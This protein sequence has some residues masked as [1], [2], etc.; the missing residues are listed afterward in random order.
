[1]RIFKL[2]KIFIITLWAVFSTIL[3]IGCIDDDLQEEQG[4]YSP[5]DETGYYLSFKINLES[6]TRGG[7]SFE[8]YEDYID[9]SK[10][11][12]LFF[13]ATDK[14]SDPSNENLIREFTNNE[15]NF[16]P[17]A[18][19]EGGSLKNWYIQIPVPTESFADSLRNSNF[20]V[21]V[22]ANWPGS[23]PHFEHGDN[24]NQL[25]HLSSSDTYEG[26]NKDTYSFLFATDKNY[27]GTLGMSSS[28][29]EDGQNKLDGANQTIR[30]DWDPSL[31]KNPTLE[32]YKAGKPYQYRTYSDLWFL[33]NFGGDNTS[34]DNYI[35]YPSHASEW[36][37]RN[38]SKLRQ[39]IT[40]NLKDADLESLK[41]QTTGNN[42]NYLTYNKIAGGRAIK[43]Q[44][45]NTSEYYYGTMI[46]KATGTGSGGRIQDTDAGVFS[47]IAKATG[48]LYITASNAGNNSGISGKAKLKVQIGS[49]TSNSTLEFES[50]PETKEM[51]ISITGDEER[52][53]IFNGSDNST[54][55]PNKA[56]IYQIEYVQDHYL[57]DTDRIGRVPDG[58]SQVIPMYGIQKFE[59]LTDWKKGTVYDLSNFNKLGITK[60]NSEISLLRSLAKVELKIPHSLGSHH[61]FLRSQNR[62]ARCEPMD[63]STPTNELWKSHGISSNDQDCE[64]FKLIGNTP[65]YDKFTTSSSSEQW[66]NYRSKLAWYHGIWS[67]D[68]KTL[69]PEGNKVTISNSVSS[70]DFPR[71]FNPMINRSDF[72]EF[73]KE[74]GIVDG[75]YDRYVLY[76]PEKY[77]DDPN[78]VG[79]NKNM[80]TSNPKVCHIEFREEGYPYTN[81][82][83]N[84]CYRIY[85]ISDGFNKEMPYPRFGKTNDKDINGN[86]IVDSS[87]NPVEIDD[88]WENTYEQNINNLQK[89]WPIMRNHIYS[90]TVTDANS[91]V[92]VVKLEVLPWR[93]IEDNSYSW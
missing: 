91:R 24:I 6:M 68:G 34:H 35:K 52:L 37:T 82:D 51:K 21:A 4:P 41:E 92:A 67:E 25:H 15:I 53:Y 72:T 50:G 56:V 84:G 20:K 18:S 44:V 27:K 42:R 70:N 19:S 61:V 63:V 78:D 31:D 74:E 76:V 11:R 43:E 49:T 90:F 17:V 1:M 47:F 40:V 75:I 3:F 2:K 9:P 26:S 22:L 85:F 55:N 64:W 54:N 12:V 88:N 8:Q 16:V 71:I 69:G 46:P 59:K 7:A 48:T 57:Y 5:G 93:M 29:I 80:E 36:E 38:G 23:T 89:H 32:E 77:V 66:N 58:N 81:L 14:T 13:T 73:V 30:K 79:S 28:W 39:W 87:G 83:D 86:T 65:F 33:W 62:S 10:V 45:S 60:E